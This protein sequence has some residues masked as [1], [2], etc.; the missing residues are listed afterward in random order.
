MITA[1][2]IWKFKW[3]NL[4][5][6]SGDYGPGKLTVYSLIGDIMDTKNPMQFGNTNT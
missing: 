5:T 6:A 1:S 4:H 2:S 3:V